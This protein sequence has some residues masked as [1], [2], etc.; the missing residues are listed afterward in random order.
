LGAKLQGI[1]IKHWETR[2]SQPKGWLTRQAGIAV[3]GE[4]DIIPPGT[5]DRAFFFI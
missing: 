1:S 5:A 3:G 4:F 2:D